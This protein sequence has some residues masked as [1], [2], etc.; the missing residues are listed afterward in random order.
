MMAILLANTILLNPT[1]WDLTLDSSGNIAMQTASAAIAQDVASVIQSF[2]G[3][4]WFDTSQGL[5]YF[6]QILGQDVNAALFAS[7]YNQAALT[8]PNVVSAFTSFTGVTSARKLSGTVEVIDTT[9]QSMN[10]SF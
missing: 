1:T 4:C 7:L 10:A 2:Q 3:E 6:A 8:V 5:P 9:G